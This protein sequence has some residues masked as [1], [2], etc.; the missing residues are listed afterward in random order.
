M[1]VGLYLKMIK[2]PTDSIAQLPHLHYAR[3]VYF[4]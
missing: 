2:T 1:V 3:D 4:E